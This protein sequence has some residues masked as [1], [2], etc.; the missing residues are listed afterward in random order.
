MHFEK[1]SRVTFHEQRRKERDLIR[2]QCIPVT[3]RTALY[4]DEREIAALIKRK[5]LVTVSFPRASTNTTDL[6]SKSTLAV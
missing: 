3:T 6:M 5:Y 1:V 4:Q 2:L